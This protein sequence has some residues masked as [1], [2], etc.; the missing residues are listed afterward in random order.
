MVPPGA[1]GRAEGRQGHPPPLHSRG[2]KQHLPP[3]PAP[4]GLNSE[5]Q[6]PGVCGEKGTRVP[7]ARSGDFTQT[8]RASRTHRQERVPRVLENA[9]LCERVG[10]LI[11]EDRAR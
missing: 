8:A 11:L 9:V 4:M 7:Q 10:H 3:T 5:A 1:S 6:E 2:S